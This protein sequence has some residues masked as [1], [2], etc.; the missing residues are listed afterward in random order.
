MHEEKDDNASSTFWVFQINCFR[1]ARERLLPLHISRINDLM[2]PGIR[3]PWHICFMRLLDLVL[4]KRQDKLLKFEV[5]GLKSKFCERAQV[6]IHSDLP[7]GSVMV[8]QESTQVIDPEFAFFSRIKFLGNL[9]LAF[10]AQDGHA[11]QAN[12]SKSFRQKLLSIDL[13]QGNEEHD[14][15]YWFGA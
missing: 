9:M 4:P 6:L 15:F 1:R 7:T 12:L 10:F 14:A 13:E 8:T 5:A 11:D 2:K 3:D